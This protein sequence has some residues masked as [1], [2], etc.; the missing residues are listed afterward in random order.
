MV[1][2]GAPTGVHEGRKAFELTGDGLWSITLSQAVAR[3]ETGSARG[4]H[5]T[6]ERAEARRLSTGLLGRQSAPG[7][8]TM[9]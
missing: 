8:I 6:P 3:M 1:N 4:W 7:T 9:P 5:C 2:D